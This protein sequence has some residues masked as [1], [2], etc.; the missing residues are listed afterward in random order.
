MCACKNYKKYKSVIFIY[1]TFRQTRNKNKPYSL[2][3]LKSFQQHFYQRSMYV[4]KPHWLNSEKLPIPTLCMI[5]VTAFHN[6]L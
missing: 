6:L 4:F 1:L 2:E 5:H 3:R